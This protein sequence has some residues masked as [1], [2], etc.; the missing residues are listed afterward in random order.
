MYLPAKAKALRNF[1][2]KLKWSLIALI[3][4]NE[5]TCFDVMVVFQM[6]KP[7]YIQDV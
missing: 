5:G 2:R 1:S 3:T 4:R 7:L 6:Y